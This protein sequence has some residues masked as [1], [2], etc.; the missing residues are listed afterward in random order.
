MGY[1]SPAWSRGP[2]PVPVY[3]ACAAQHTQRARERGGYYF[4]I[5]YTRKRPLYFIFFA[6]YK[7]FNIYIILL[8][9]YNNFIF[10]HISILDIL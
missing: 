7:I 6:F 9:L 1:V 8:I 3:R 10:R 4:F 2:C 5:F